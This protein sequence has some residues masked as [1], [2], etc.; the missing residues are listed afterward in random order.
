MRL[1]TVRAGTWRPWHHRRK[2]G[3]CPQV[4]VNLC[5]QKIKNKVCLS[6]WQAS[7]APGF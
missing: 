4:R 1:A 3:P 6:D 7:K 2:L 5:V